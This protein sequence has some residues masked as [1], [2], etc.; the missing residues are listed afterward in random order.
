MKKLIL[1]LSIF[2]LAAAVHA[3]NTYN[4]SRLLN[5]ASNLSRQTGDLA[6][7]TSSDLRRGSFHS[8]SDIEAAFSASQVDAGA[9]LFEQMVR[10]S[11][12]DSELRDAASIMTDIARRASGSG[13]SSYLWR[14]VQNSV[15]DI[16]RELGG[17][18]S[19]NGSSGYGGN[20][21]GYGGGSNNGGG[22]D[23]NNDDNR[24]VVGRVKWYGKVDVE[25]QLFIKGGNLETRVVSGPNWGG[26]GFSFTS[27]L[28]ARKIEVGVNMK[29]GRGEAH[30]IQQPSKDNDYTA[31]V[32]ILDPK[33][34]YKDYE[35]D[36][37]WR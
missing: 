25:T 5:L 33:G 34:S 35:L 37:Y 2:A 27:P 15:A 24:P 28:P 30:V 22:Y 14:N 17:Y 36:I 32:Q 3:Q 20:N 8:R 1:L 7:R 31:V 18:G 26:E 9:R 23:R 19:G 21:G 10:D 4:S 11:R 16:Q 6:N 12:S 13:S 29:K